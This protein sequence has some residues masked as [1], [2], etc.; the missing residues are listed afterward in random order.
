M[1][2]LE[3]QEVKELIAQQPMTGGSRKKYDW[4][5][6]L[7]GNWHRLV[8]GTDFT[9][10]PL[11]FRSRIYTCARDRGLRAHVYEVQIPKRGWLVRAYS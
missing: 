9:C 2:T 1:D 11:A 8:T 3:N 5:K 10:E 4:D 7:D 6:I